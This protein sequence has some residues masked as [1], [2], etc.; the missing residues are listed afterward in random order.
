MGRPATL[1]Q[2]VLFEGI[3]ERLLGS[4]LPS[5][6][7]CWNWIHAKNEAG[8]GVTKVN[9]R[10]GWVERVHRVSYAVF[11]G[12]IAPG[13]CVL[14]RCDNRQCFNPEHLFLGSKR[15][16]TN[17]M[18]SKGRWREPEPSRGSKAGTSKLSEQQVEEVIS[19]LLAGETRTSIAES[20]GVSLSTISKIATGKNWAHLTAG[21]GIQKST[22]G[23]SRRSHV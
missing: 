7:G 9:G 17:D 1:N 18:L 3:R 5:N 21:R 20:L 14:H 4:Y 22:R 11:V 19:R 15:D 6:S 13:V 23:I 8:Y 16:N 2:A 10:A 12:P